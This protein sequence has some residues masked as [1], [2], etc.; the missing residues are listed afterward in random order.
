VQDVSYGV[1]K[2]PDSGVLRCFVVGYCSCGASLFSL[3]PL[4][5]FLTT[6]EKCADFV[7]LA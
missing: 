1:A 7:S 5:G 2:M 4:A 6:V 3:I